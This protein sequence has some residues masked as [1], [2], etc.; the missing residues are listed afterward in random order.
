MSNI[1][2]ALLV[3][4]LFGALLRMDW[5]YY[6]AYVVGG[7]WLFSMWSVRRSLARLGVTRHL[8]DRGFVGQ[9]IEV[10]VQLT[11]RSRLPLPWVR[12]EERVPLDLKDIAQYTVALSVG[13]RSTTEHTYTLACK[14][15]GYYPLGP[16]SL[17][18]G[19][20]FGFVESRWEEEQ[21]PRV[22]VFP[23][24]VPLQELGLPSRIPM[25][26]QATPQRLYEDPAR[27]RGVRAYAAG[28]SQR[29][30]HWKA[31]AH[32]DTLLVKTFQPAIGLQVVV[33]LDFAR[34]A[35]GTRHVVSTSEWAVTVAASVAAYVAGTR[36]PVGLLCHATDA[37]SGT[38]PA[39]LPPRSGQA[40][41]QA[42]LSTL[43]R[44]LLRDPP[45][46]GDAAVPDFA[47]WLTEQTAALEWGTTLVAV[48]PHVSEDLLWVLHHAYR[49]GMT[50]L[51]LQCADQPGARSLGAR[52][53]RL[54]IEYHLVLWDRDLQAV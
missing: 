25:G 27:L 43:A 24:I 3:L 14:R 2:W 23:L 45:A 38:P 7:V 47:H 32:A 10:R 35:Y 54:G 39:A 36:Q 44:A 49:R 18:T 21:P 33:A 16:L 51:L 50:P 53:G 5:V 11:N 22:T 29:R 26:G 46:E 28:D 20:L 17:R 41:L 30:I 42:V 4:F 9:Q 12:L 15:R 6:L 8:L 34:A 48:T 31:S 1:F 52:A 40:Q 13:S 19:D 37:A